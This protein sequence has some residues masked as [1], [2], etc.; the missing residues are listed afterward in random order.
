ME[1]VIENAKQAIPTVE[2]FMMNRFTAN[3][4][5]FIEITCQQQ[6]LE[7]I[8]SIYSDIFMKTFMPPPMIQP[9][10]QQMPVAWGQQPGM[11]R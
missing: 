6:L 5:K 8:A 7:M 1:K 2:E 10:P 3:E 9:V 11:M 4:R